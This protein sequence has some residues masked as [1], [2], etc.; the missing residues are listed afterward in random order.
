MS[1]DNEESPLIPSEKVV[2]T[3]LHGNNNFVSTLDHLP[4]DITRS[5]WIIQMMGLKNDRLKVK[6]NTLLNDLNRDEKE[7]LRINENILRNA[8][9]AD[10]EAKYA[11]S[12]LNNHL[13]ILED[14]CNILDILKEKLKGWTSEA[15]E[16]RWIEWNSFKKKIL[17]EN[18]RKSDEGVLETFSINEE[19]TKVE[20]NIE[21][22]KHSIIKNSS[23]KNRNGGLKIKLS[24]K[25]DTKSSK[26][27]NS[28]KKR[29]ESF[30]LPPNKKSKQDIAVVKHSDRSKDRKTNIGGNDKKKNIDNK[31]ITHP[32]IEP[33]IEVENIISK[34]LKI[35]PETYCFC[36]GP[37]FGRM[38]ACDNE[39]CLR[40]WFHFK[41]VGLTQEPNGLW[42][43]SK[44]CED[45][46]NLSK[47]R[48]Q[49]K[50]KRRW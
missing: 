40:Q 13:N 21:T 35:E 34:P 25:P 27:K 12:I 16:K 18:R 20:Q 3:I 4:C 43:C 36:N 42:F 7:L 47:V 32:T 11:I 9:E 23:N 10:R 38:V 15:V 8:R 45:Q 48:K 2:D 19:I 37:S 31:E 6:F 22:K 26:V 46:F 44:S 29:K 30:H 50:K 49:K 17:N 33:I 1:T 41:C 28:G 39:K 24:L 5:L 14:D